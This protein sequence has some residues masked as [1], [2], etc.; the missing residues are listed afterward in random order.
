MMTMNFLNNTH[1]DNFH[2]LIDISKIYMGD[3]ERVSLFYILSG[4]DDLFSKKQSIYNFEEN[5]LNF[6]GFKK[7]K[8]D[9]CQSSKALIRLGLNLFNGYWDRYTNP[10]LILGYLDYTNY[11]LAINAIEIRF[12]F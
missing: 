6:H 10:L 4:N 8:V 9:F 7:T 2:K 1:R 3:T 5:E 11:N 12:S